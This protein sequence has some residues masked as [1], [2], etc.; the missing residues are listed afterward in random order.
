METASIM[1][2]PGHAREDEVGSDSNDEE[3]QA[4]LA[5]S[6]PRE[7]ATTTKQPTANSPHSTNAPAGRQHGNKS[8]TRKVLPVP[9]HDTNIRSNHIPTGPRFNPH[10]HQRGNELH[11]GP[12]SNHGRAREPVP[13]PHKKVSTE[14]KK[15]N[16]HQISS[17]TFANTSSSAAQPSVETTTPSCFRCKQ[18]GPLPVLKRSCCLLIY[19]T[20]CGP[21]SS[22]K[23][24]YPLCIHRREEMDENTRKA[25]TMRQV[26]HNPSSELHWGIEREPDSNS[27]NLGRDSQSRRSG[28]KRRRHK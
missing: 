25:E 27:C 8:S 26:A 2:G 3:S 23:Y 20:S 9:Q 4:L 14:P 7:F 6:S 13:I 19:C 15:R 18:R 10:D 11:S 1:Q 12:A 21:H 5:T 22:A 28:P 16:H 17:S 24:K